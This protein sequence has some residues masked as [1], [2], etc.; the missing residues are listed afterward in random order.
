SSPP[1]ST[2]SEDFSSGVIP[3]PIL[4]L[5]DETM[6]LIGTCWNGPEGFLHIGQGGVKAASKGSDL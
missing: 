4:S 3:G 6:K 1:D 2:E 5:V